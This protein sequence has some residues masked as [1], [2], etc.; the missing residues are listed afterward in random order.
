MHANPD[1]RVFLK[2]RITGSG[3]VITAVIQLKESTMNV[4][5]KFGG[6][7]LLLLGSL[8]LS[9]IAVCA[10]GGGCDVDGWWYAKHSFLGI[11]FLYW[12]FSLYWP[13]VAHQTD[14]SQSAVTHD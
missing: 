8:K 13:D 14:T 10:I 2:W 1:L 11:G 6:C 9:G 12:G 7:L 5:R 4:L 3:S